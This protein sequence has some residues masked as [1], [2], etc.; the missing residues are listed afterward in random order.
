MISVTSDMILKAV[1]F[2]AISGAVFGLFH[3]L[4]LIVIQ[5]APRLF[6]KWFRERKL[7]QPRYGILRH[8][9]D[10][11]TVTAMLVLYL[12]SGYAFLDGA[13]EIYSVSALLIAYAV[14]DRIF[15]TVFG[16]CRQNTI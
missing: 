1:I 11:L 14:F 16:L 8:T 12:L 4:F 10:F 5:A 9:V 15:S 2:S 13:Y 3:S 6:L 7:R